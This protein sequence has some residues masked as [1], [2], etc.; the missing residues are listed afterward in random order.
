MTCF[1]NNAS[2]TIATN[3]NTIAISLHTLLISIFSG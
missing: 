1:E 3:K 2:N